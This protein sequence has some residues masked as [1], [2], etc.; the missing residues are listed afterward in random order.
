[1]RGLR[2]TVRES[3]HGCGTRTSYLDGVATG[4]HPSAEFSVE[5]PEN[6]LK[7]RVDLVLI[8]GGAGNM[9]RKLAL[10]LAEQGHR[11]RALCLP[12]DPGLLD[13]IGGPVELM[14]GDITRKETLGPVLQGV[15]TVFH[16]AAVLLAPGRPEVFRTVN[17]EGTRNLAE[18]AVSAGVR[19]FIYVSSISVAYP[20]S[21]AYARSKL[22]GEEYVKRS[23]LPFT[24]VRPS[25]AYQEGGAIEFM[26]FVAHLKKGPVVFLP[27]GGRARKSPVHIADL[28]AGFAAL[29]GNPLALGKTYVF[30][31]GEILTLREMAVRLLAHMDRPKPVIGVP[32]WLCLP[33]IALLSVWSKLTGRENPFTYQTYTGLMQDAAP[34]SDAAR[35]DLGYRPRSF[36]KGLETLESLRGCL[37]RNGKSI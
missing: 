15:D 6:A 22:L 12:D 5:T 37:R 34:E 13:L 18:A 21:N 31:G 27:G 23:G 28:V 14:S 32:G 8:T 30:S 3:V 20:S 35:A 25:L 1:M 7:E 24:I 9:G 17:A 33:G 36:R 4:G 10:A 26:R 16:L 2:I 11:V 29:S 19:H